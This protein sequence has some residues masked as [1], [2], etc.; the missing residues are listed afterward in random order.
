MH[1]TTE[2]DR[3]V[4]VHVSRDGEAD[5]VGDGDLHAVHCSLLLDKAVFEPI[6]QLVHDGSSVEYFAA[7]VRHSFDY[8]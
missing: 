4:G 7:A 5:L 1:E 8:Q 6:S 3:I 2:F